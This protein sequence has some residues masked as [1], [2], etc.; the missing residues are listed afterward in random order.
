MVIVEYLNGFS[1]CLG[2]L[3]VQDAWCHKTN[4]L[5]CGQQ[6]LDTAKLLKIK[7]LTEMPDSTSLRRSQ[8]TSAD[9]HQPGEAPGDAQ[10]H[11]A[12]PT[13]SPTMKR[14]RLVVWSVSLILYEMVYLCILKYKARVNSA[15]ALTILFCNSHGNDTAPIIAALLRAVQN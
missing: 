1:L 4:C 8:G 15:F 5:C 11:S 9:F 12:S 2:L 7:G 14:K 6:V 13:S 10:R 3:Y